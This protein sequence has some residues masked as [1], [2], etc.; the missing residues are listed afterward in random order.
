[1]RA[2]TELI[3]LAEPAG[4]DVDPLTTPIYETTT[5]VFENAEQVKAFNAGTSSKFL[6]SRYGNPTVAAV[7]HTIA[8]L[9][10][11][12]RALLFGSG[13][14]ATSTALLAL[15][16]SGDEVV[17]SAAI[18][19]GTLHLLADLFPRWG[20]SARFASL[21]ELRNPAAMLGDRTKLVWFESPINPTLRCVDIAAIAS[22]CRTRGVTSVIDNTFASPLNQQPISLGVDVVMHSVTKYL[23]GHSDI[24]A[25]A[26]AGPAKTLER[27]DKTRRLLGGIIDPHA[28]YAIGRGLKTLPVR[29]ERHN[30]NALAVARWLEQDPRVARVLYPGLATHPD[31][32]LARRQMRGFG[33]MVCVDVGGGQSN[34][35]R[36]FDRLKVI[37]RAASLGG[38]ESLCSL[39]VLTS[40]WGCSDAQ[41]AEAGITRSMA[42]LSIG[43]EDPQ[44]L[45]ED[46]DQALGR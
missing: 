1:M 13:M 6:Y 26:I 45:I 22:A 32:E 15:L 8:A 35:E 40:Q 46:L 24:T 42:R 20:I 23:N 19:G 30:A 16:E 34:A 27:I 10:G 37:R 39:P 25:G 31:H 17:C 4:R 2:A 43:L 33:G 18:Y 7:E 14:A 28:A 3:H 11:A 41:L 29:I 5:F 21:E 38:V 36:F 12:E 9:E 44:D